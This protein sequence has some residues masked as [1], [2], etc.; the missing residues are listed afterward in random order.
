[1]KKCIIVGAGE[2][3][4]TSLPID[5]K[6]Y[7][8]AADGGYDNLRSINVTP[9]IF[10]GDKD[11][12]NSC[13][14]N[15]SSI[16]FPAKKDDSDLL[17]SVNHAIEKGFRLFY[18]FGGMGGRIDHTIA[19]IKILH[20]LSSLGMRGY[21]FS[22]DEVITVIHNEGITFPSYFSGNFSVFSLGGD[23]L[24]VNEKGAEYSLCS[25]TLTSDSSIGLSNRFCKKEAVVSIDNGTLAI[26]FTRQGDF[27]VGF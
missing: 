25:Y 11:S 13:V 20:Y 27:K 23:S 14:E 17:L 4:E 9:H 3:C 1:M 24:G 12:V 5:T 8:I 21:L 26:I 7:I 19:N 2:F 10:I 6:D 22:K 16:V 15:L 18:I